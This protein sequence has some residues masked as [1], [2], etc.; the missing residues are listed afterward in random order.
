MRLDFSG[1]G[2]FE[3]GFGQAGGAILHHLGEPLLA[4]IVDRSDF[5]HIEYQPTAAKNGAGG[6]PAATQLAYIGLA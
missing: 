6:F 4:C 3:E 5:A 1:Y 2:V